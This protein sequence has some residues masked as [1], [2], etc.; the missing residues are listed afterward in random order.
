MNLDIEYR[1]KTF[2]DF[3]GNENIVRDI[4]AFLKTEDAPH[5]MFVG[6]PG[7]GK[8]SMAY[9]FASYYFDKQIGIH[10][11]N[12]EDGFKEI[13][14]SDERG[15]DTV[16]GTIKDYAQSKCPIPDKRKILLINEVDSTTNEFQH[17][18]RTE[19]EKWEH[20]CIFI[21][22]MNRIEGIKE[23]ALISRCAKFYF[24]RPTIKQMGDHFKKIANKEGVHFSNKNIPYDIAEYYNGD[25]RHMLA[26][27]L[28]AL[29]GY[30]NKDAITK[31]DVYKVYNE[32]GKSVAK[33]VVSSDDHMNTFFDIYRKETVNV[34]EFLTEYFE[35]L[36]EYAYEF[37]D[38]FATTDARIRDNCDPVI[39]LSALFLKLSKK[40]VKKE[41]KTWK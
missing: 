29:R 25:L 22:T 15:I 18:L 20:N 21:F 6:Q 34:R 17:A 26:D 33:R 23:P 40:K 5:M 39:Q 36:G 14:A 31:S 35:I 3:V 27:C 19:T 37:A 13:N 38:C 30:E 9:L 28:E 2:D 7:T 16:R 4:K 11:N 1:P 12:K 10:T 8:T 24:E 41:V 32:S